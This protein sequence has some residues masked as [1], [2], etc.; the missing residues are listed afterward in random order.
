MF[1]LT[2]TPTLNA[3]RVFTA[4]LAWFAGNWAAFQSLANGRASGKTQLR[5]PRLIQ[6][7]DGI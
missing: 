3:K 1:E 2:R 5:R 4:R 6:L 7:T